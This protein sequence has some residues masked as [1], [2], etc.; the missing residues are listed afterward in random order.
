MVEQTSAP[1]SF[2]ARAVPVTGIERDAIGEGGSAER[3]VTTKRTDREKRVAGAVD[4]LP[5]AKGYCRPYS[6]SEGN[7]GACH[8]GKGRVGLHEDNAGIRRRRM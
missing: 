7:D 5:G 6:G 4:V 8:A 3:F 1:A 2:I